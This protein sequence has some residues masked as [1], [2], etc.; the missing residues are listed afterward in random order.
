MEKYIE[1][2][3]SESTVALWDAGEAVF[4]RQMRPASVHI[5]KKN[6]F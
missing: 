3:E 6:G 1:L 4:R 2:D 5:L